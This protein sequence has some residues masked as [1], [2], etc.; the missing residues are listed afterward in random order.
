MPNGKQI[1]A[2]LGDFEWNGV[3][4]FINKCFENDKVK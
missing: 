3:E 1:L 2:A 4:D